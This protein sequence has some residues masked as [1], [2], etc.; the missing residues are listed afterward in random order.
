MSVSSHGSAKN[1]PQ[2]RL[3]PIA[4]LL[5]EKKEQTR[6]CDLVRRSIPPFILLPTLESRLDCPLTLTS[7][8]CS[9]GLCRKQVK[10]LTKLCISIS[11]LRAYFKKW[12]QSRKH[13]H[14]KCKKS[15]TDESHLLLTVSRPAPLTYKYLVHPLAVPPYSIKPKSRSLWKRHCST[16]TTT[17]L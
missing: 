13:P 1:I 7:F 17:R 3:L 10:T 6:L 11:Q 9:T 4:D 12:L 8:S 16:P 15:T 14:T 5:W 2:H